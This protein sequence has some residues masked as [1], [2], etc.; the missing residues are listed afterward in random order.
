MNPTRQKALIDQGAQLSMDLE[1]HM[2]QERMNGHL[3]PTDSAIL[4]R[5][6]IFLRK[7]LKE[8]LE[9]ETPPKQG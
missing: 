8:E 1:S 6:S 3:S 2:R 7:T 5:V 4:Q 9:K